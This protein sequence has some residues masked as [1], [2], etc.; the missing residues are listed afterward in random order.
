MKTGFWLGICALVA[1]LTISLI[2]KPVPIDEKLIRLQTARWVPEDAEKLNRHPLHVQAVFIDYAQADEPALLLQARLALLRHPQMTG[3]VLALYGDDPAFQA[4]LREYGVHAIAPIHYFLDNEIRA[5]ALMHRAGEWAGSAAS[6]L[7]TWRGAEAQAE[8]NPVVVLDPTVRGEYAIAFI[9]KEGYDFIGQFVVVADGQVSW[10]QT[11]RVL[12]GLNAFFAGGVRALETR[13]R[14]DETLA[15]ADVGWAAVDVAL[16]VSVVKVLRVARMPALAGRSVGF[17]ERTALMGASL[18]R[19][20]RIG[21]R[22]AKIG[23]PV[24]LAYIVVRHP[25]LLD[26]MFVH[27]A[28]RL[29]L[30]VLLVRT[31]GWALVLFPL[32]V[33]IRVLLGPLAWLFALMAGAL[34][35][36]DRLMR[37][38]RAHRGP[39]Q[40]HRPRALGR[41]PRISPTT[42][43][44]PPAGADRIEMQE[45]AN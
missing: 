13:V 41:E 6:A 18:L 29:G 32:L 26:S 44:R 45:A 2:A 8:R 1:A 39:T 30:P 11:E 43:S 12:E 19:G 17:S 40:P 23:A 21:I 14:K 35:R 34:R 27:V 36:C 7:R 37:A 15:F 31:L 16:G 24:A 28:D 20:S 9:A 5:L 3:R 10:V 25:S 22:L 42:G 4:V 33:L 38:T